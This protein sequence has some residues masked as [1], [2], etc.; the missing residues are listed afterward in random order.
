M[1]NP[2]DVVGRDIHHLN[3]PPADD[4]PGFP[5]APTRAAGALFSCENQTRTN[6]VPKN[7]KPKG[8]RPAAN[9]EPRYAKKTS[10]HDRHRQGRRP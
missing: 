6:P 9:F 7:H 4:C 3:G 2:A 8:G 5:A 10:F 1:V